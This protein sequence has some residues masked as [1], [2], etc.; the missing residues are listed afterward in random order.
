MYLP[1]GG[2]ISLLYPPFL[3]VLFPRKSKLIKTH[4]GW[5]NVIESYKGGFVSQ[6]SEEKSFQLPFLNVLLDQDQNYQLH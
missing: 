5:R 1:R 4:E 3:R 6:G 2:Q